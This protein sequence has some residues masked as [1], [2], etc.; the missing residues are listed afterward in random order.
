VLDDERGF[1]FHIR[2]FRG[3]FEAIGQE[4]VQ[5]WIDANGELAARRVARHLIGPHLSEEGE[6]IIPPLT[7]WLLTT[8]GDNKEVF[9]EFCMGRH[10]GEVRVGHAR[11]RHASVMQQIAPFVHHEKKWVRDWAE[12]ERKS[13]EDE[14]KW[15][16]QI[17]DEHKRA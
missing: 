13:F 5:R 6:P 16:D 14:V 12:Y 17:E 1:I 11:D 9:S 8:F 3:L 2:V 15:D 10:S 4:E 7:D